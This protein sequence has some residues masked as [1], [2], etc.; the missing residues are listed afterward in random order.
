MYRLRWFKLSSYRFML[1]ACQQVFSSMSRL[2]PL[3]IYR[4]VYDKIDIRIHI[5]G[6]LCYR[7]VYLFGYVARGTAIRFCYLPKRSF[8]PLQRAQSFLVAMLLCLH[9]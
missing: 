8:Q 1:A 4:G 7:E 3:C 5:L 2:L 9:V 6:T